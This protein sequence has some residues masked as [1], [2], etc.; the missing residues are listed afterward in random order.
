[1][2]IAFSLS[3]WGHSPNRARAASLLRFLD[4]SLTHTHTHSRQDSSKRVISPSQRPHKHTTQISTPSEGFFFVLCTLSVLLC[5]DCPGFAFCPYCTTHTTQT[6]MPPAGFEPAI[7][8]SDRPQTL[9]LDLSDTGIGR[10][11]T[12]DLP[13]SSAVLNQ[14][15]HQAPYRVNRQWNWVLERR[16]DKIITFIIQISFLGKGLVAIQTEA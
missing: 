9:A 4:L 12:R 16:T 14:V 13:S 1:M 6:S 3:P 8:A 15:R 11:R 2:R 7:P 10:N 5:P